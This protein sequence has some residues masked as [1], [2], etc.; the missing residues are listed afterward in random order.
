M[1]YA[2]LP[3]S[4]ELD[5][6]IDTILNIYVILFYKW[7]INS[8]KFKCIYGIKK[9]DLSIGKFTMFEFDFV[10][11]SEHQL[12]KR[13]NS[14]SSPFQAISGSEGAVDVEW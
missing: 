2:K 7:L 10:T 8:I 12:K 1:K 6:K 4:G 9:L 13:Y 14:W 3:S 5:K 11:C